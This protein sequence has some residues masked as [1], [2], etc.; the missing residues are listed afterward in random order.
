MNE[1]LLGSESWVRSQKQTAPGDGMTI[2]FRGTALPGYQCHSPP[3]NQALS[4]AF[5]LDLREQGKAVQRRQ[6]PEQTRKTT[7]LRSAREPTEGTAASRSEGSLPRP[8]ASCPARR[9]PAA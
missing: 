6:R 3:P 4:S 8:H 5:A 1:L 7:F 9:L 2:F